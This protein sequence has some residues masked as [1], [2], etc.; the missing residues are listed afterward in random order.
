MAQ[1]NRPKPQ[2]EANLANRYSMK[3]MLSPEEIARHLQREEMEMDST[4]PNQQNNETTMEQES[5]NIEE[6]KKE[7][8][9]LFNSILDASNN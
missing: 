3:A 1:S 4:T 5:M 6:E 8:E 9:E 2:K 7:S